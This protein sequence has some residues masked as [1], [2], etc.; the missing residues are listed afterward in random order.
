MGVV[1]VIGF[2]IPDPTMRMGSAAELCLAASMQVPALSV[3]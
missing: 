3:I 2:Y 1:N